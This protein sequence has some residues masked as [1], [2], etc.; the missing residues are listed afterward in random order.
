MLQC[1][2]NHDDV[3]AITEGNQQDPPTRYWEYISFASPDTGNYIL[4][5]PALVSFVSLVGVDRSF[6]GPLFIVTSRFPCP[7]HVAHEKRR[8]TLS[9]GTRHLSKGRFQ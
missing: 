9:L 8:L 2:T 1:P 3:T 4:I 6:L 5:G 7:R